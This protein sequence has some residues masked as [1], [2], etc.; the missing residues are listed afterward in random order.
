MKIGIIA[1]MEEELNPLLMETHIEIE[2]V[3]AKMHYYQGTLRNK[4]VVLVVSGIGKVNAAVCSQILIDE[5]KVDYIIN[6]G[7]AGGAMDEIKPLDIVIGDNLLQ[8]D[9]DT[10]VFGDQV[11]QVPRLDTYDFKCDEKLIKIAIESAKSSKVNIHVGRI[12]SGDQFI[13]DGPKI[14]SLRE[15]FNAF[16]CEMEGGSIAQVCYLNSIPFVVIRSISDNAA[17]GAH[18]DYDKFKALAVDNSTAIIRNML[19]LM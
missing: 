16:A 4:N 9:M 18:M 6:V 8:H 2:L 5:F 17:T 3:K 15:Q 13:A 7:V 12:V 19:S 10:S 1:A 11:G 14:R